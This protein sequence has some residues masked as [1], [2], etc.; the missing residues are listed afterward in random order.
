MIDSGSRLYN[1][2]VVRKA[3]AAVLFIAVLCGRVCGQQAGVAGVALDSVT[4]QPLAGVHISLRPVGAG[5]LEAE[6][7]PVRTRGAISKQNGSFSIASV[8]AGSYTLSAQRN[9]YMQLVSIPLQG[10]SETFPGRL[11]LA[12]KA[13]E[14]VTGLRVEMTAEAFMTGHVFDE[15]G[16]PLED[17]LIEAESAGRVGGPPTEARTDERG[18]FRLVLWPGKFYLKA[19]SMRVP[20]APPGID[21]NAAEPTYLPTYYPASETRASAA[22]I[23]TA[24]GQETTDIDFHLTPARGLRISGTVSG[25]PE[26]G[27]QVVVFLEGVRS[28]PISTVGTFTFAGLAPREYRLSA[29]YEGG[30][31]PMQSQIAEIRLENADETGVVLTLVPAETVSGTV[32]IAGGSVN[33]VNSGKLN[34]QLLR[35]RDNFDGDPRRSPADS[36]GR[37]RIEDVFPGRFEIRVLPLPENAY[38]KSIKVDN[39]DASDGIIDFSRGVNRASLR[40]TISLGGA[41]VEGRVVGKDGKP[42]PNPGPVFLGTAPENTDDDHLKLSGPD[43]SFRFTGLR[44]GKYRL[45]AIDPRLAGSGREALKLLFDA[46]P[47]FEI[48]ERDRIRK[49]AEI[50]LPEAKNAKP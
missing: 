14:D 40:V 33:S 34:V 25:I 1:I 19:K 15:N 9:G 22:V 38:V 27:K 24:P 8:P 46:A 45:I 7:D 10:G 26:A 4:H 47:E 30:P 11:P 44:P 13:G 32:E 29:R 12:V 5:E 16:D 36:E 18:Q 43:G 37:F 28:F 39:A 50:A 48:H 17:F 35:L 31:K 42:A 20:A 6:E 41:T 23:E 3:E 49:D 2:R 21:G